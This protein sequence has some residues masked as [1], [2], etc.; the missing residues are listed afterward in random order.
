MARRPT[1]L[2]LLLCTLFTAA[3]SAPGLAA[4][5][6]ERGEPTRTILR[7]SNYRVL[8]DR[9]RQGYP[10]CGASFLYRK[11]TLEFIFLRPI[12]DGRGQETFLTRSDDLGKTWSD[13]VSFGPPVGNPKKLYQ[14]ASL[15][16]VTASGTSLVTS[17][18][19]PR[20]PGRG[21][22]STWI[23]HPDYRPLRK[24]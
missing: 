4:P 5:P 24:E 10:T 9:V 8:F 1:T 20:I 16:G 11:G 23:G 18:F 2:A 19:T 7:F 15:V 6:S 13:P 14:N 12:E 17:S 21:Y 22:G 3:R